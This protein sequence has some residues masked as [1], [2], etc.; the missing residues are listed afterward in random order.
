[1]RWEVRSLK[2]LAG[3]EQGFQRIYV[4]MFWSSKM[5]FVGGCN[6]W[7]DFMDIFFQKFDSRSIAW[8]IA[9]EIEDG[10][11]WS[12][13]T[14]IQKMCYLQ[15]FYLFM[16]CEKMANINWEVMTF[17]PTP[18]FFQCLGNSE[19][20]QLVGQA[21]GVLPGEVREFNNWFQWPRFSLHPIWMWK[22]GLSWDVIWG[23]F[24]PIFDTQPSILVWEL[25]DSRSCWVKIGK[26]MLL[27]VS[28]V[29]F[30]G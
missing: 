13:I 29:V 20:S 3:T 22:K 8:C 21:R 28:V 15:F 14:D 16:N 30:S 7:L 5:E 19:G 18:Q 9:L 17:L 6:T 25:F 27:L 26:Y 11:G 24:Y 12:I 1:M 23:C 4:Y 10:F 2:S